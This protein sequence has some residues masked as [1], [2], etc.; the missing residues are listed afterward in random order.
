[1]A[2]L[3]AFFDKENFGKNLSIKYFHLIVHLALT[4]TITLERSKHKN[5]YLN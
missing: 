5:A 1:M 2:F 4:N 3:L